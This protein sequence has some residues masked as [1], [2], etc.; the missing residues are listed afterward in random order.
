MEEKVKLSV[1]A[2]VIC[3]GAVL[4][5]KRSA[6]DAFLPNIWEFPGGGVEEGETIYQALVR[7]L[8]EEINLDVSTAN[9]QLIG[10]SEELS[11]KKEMKHEIQFNYE[12]VL[13]DRLPVSLSSEHSEYDW[14]EQCD[15]RVDDFLR[16]ILKQS[17][18]GKKLIK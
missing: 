9:A 5:I 6:V 10:I 12:I 15:D 3:H 16:N 2:V 18:W 4:I 1:C 13:S 11:A 14:I 8:K 17:Q 7:E